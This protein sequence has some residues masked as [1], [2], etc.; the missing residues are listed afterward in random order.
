M[1]ISGE[2]LDLEA[3]GVAAPVGR[4]GRVRQEIC[5]RY[6][7]LWQEL[8]RDLGLPG[9]QA[10]LHRPPHP[11]PQRPR[12]RRGRDADRALLR[13]RHGHL[14][15]QGRRRRP[16]PAPAAAADRPGHR[17]EPGP[18]PA[19]RPGELDGHPGRL[20]AR[21]TRL[22]ARPEVLAH[23]WV[24]D[25]FRPDR[26]GG[27]AGAARHDG[28]GARST[29]S[30]W[31][32]A[33]TCP[34]GRSTTSGWTTAVEDY[35]VNILPKARET[36][37]L[38]TDET[39]A[40]RLSHSCGTTATGQC[41]WCRTPWATEPIRAPTAERWARR[42]TTMSCARAGHRQQHLPRA[43]HLHVLDDRHVGEA[44][45]PR[46]AARRPA[47]SAR[48]APCPRPRRG[49]SSSRGCRRTPAAGSRP[50]RRGHRRRGPPPSRT[51]TAGL[52]VLSSGSPCWPTTTSRPAASPRGAVPAR[53]STTGRVASAITCW[54]DGAEQ[55]PEDGPVP[56]GAEHQHLGPRRGLGEQHVRRTALHHVGGDV[57]LRMPLGDAPRGLVHALAAPTGRG[58]PGS[59]PRT[60]GPATSCQ[61]CTT[62]SA[63]SRRTASRAAQAS[64][65]MTLGDSVHPCG[66]RARH[67]VASG[68]VISDRT[69]TSLHYPA[70]MTLE[71][72]QVIV[73]AADPAALGRWWA[74]ALGWVVVDDSPEEY[75]IRPAPDRMPGLL[76]VHVPEPKTVKNRLHLDFRP[77]D[78]A[79][80]GRPA[81]GPRSSPR[82]H[83]PGRAVLD[84]SGGPGG[85]RV[86]CARLAAELTGAKR[87]DRTYDESKATRHR[88]DAA[89]SM[90]SARGGRRMA[91]AADTART[92]IMTVDDD[93]GVSRA[94]AR[95][96]RRRYGESY[97]I[98]RAESGESAL[99]ALRELKLRGDLVAVILADYR[100]PQ[101]NGIEF[102]EQALDV[103]PGARRVLLTAYADT[104][105][106]DRRDQRRRPRPLPAQAVGPAGGEALPGAR[107]SAGGLAVQRLPAGARAP[108][109]SGTAG[110]RARRTYGSSWPA[111]RCRT[112]GT[113]PTSRR[114]SG[115]SRPPGRTGS[116][117][118]W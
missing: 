90:P 41:A 92:V 86:L 47:P 94:V 8:T 21:A 71:W 57:Q 103:Y 20:R 82:G 45:P 38:P 61:A 28:P 9:G 111:T 106:G 15:A 88:A 116:G 30:C 6:S 43:A 1:N 35:I 65:A 19:Q 93:P 76:F 52:G 48:T 91:Q 67:A 2:L 95:D 105:R 54:P 79:G 42:P 39:G 37:P 80:R 16:P 24:R 51:R 64:A 49:A 34:S 13:R 36:L 110:R 10:P 11:P 72:E 98:V 96:L 68:V 114:G 50:V 23:R 26:A 55:E 60:P 53:T 83:R 25:V 46:L 107:R 66:D 73:N 117:C 44:L 62:R 70:R 78:Q 84:H 101:M 63:R 97:R 31:S 87:D 4:P 56:A 81:A 27:A 89:R 32:T 77:D 113:P 118:R 112:A 33:G 40:A 75:E 5:A 58:S 102:L 3:A 7:G 17:G 29:T 14:R 22:G 108:R 18:R 69:G 104:E 100:M 99:D 109:W 85:Q 12:L 59:R 74:E 115:C